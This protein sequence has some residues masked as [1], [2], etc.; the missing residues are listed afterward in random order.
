MNIEF[1]LVDDKELPPLVI[2]MDDED[3]PKVVINTYY[4]IWISLHRKT[5][6]GI[7]A[8]LQEKMDEILVGF[9]KEQRANE[10]MYGDLE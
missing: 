5:I 8:A 9:L 4:R 6:A 3:K 1:R 7:T 10:K 2:S